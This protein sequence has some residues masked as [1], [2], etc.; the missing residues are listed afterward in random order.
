MWQPDII[1]ADA[2]QQNPKLEKTLQA[3]NG[4][5][6][7]DIKDIDEIFNKQFLDQINH[8]TADQILKSIPN[9]LKSDPEVQNVIRVFQ[10]RLNV[11]GNNQFNYQEATLAPISPELD[12]WNNI[13]NLSSYKKDIKKIKKTISQYL[14][15]IQWSTNLANLKNNLEMINKILNSDKAKL[16]DLRKIDQF[17]TNNGITD[18]NWDQTNIWPLLAW[19]TKFL[20]NI[21]QSMENH[22]NG[23]RVINTNRER[24]DR[25]NA[26]LQETLRE[27]ARC[28]INL[29]NKV[30]ND[31]WNLSEFSDK[32][33]KNITDYINESKYSSYNELRA[34]IF[35]VYYRMRQHK[36]LVDTNGKDANGNTIK[37]KDKENF[38]KIF[39]CIEDNYIKE[40]A[41]GAEQL[42]DYEL[43]LFFKNINKTNLQNLFTNSN[44][45]WNWENLEGDK[46]NNY[47][48]NN[49]CKWYHFTAEQ[50]KQRF[51]LI[52]KERVDHNINELK[53]FDKTSIF[54]QEELENFTIEETI[55]EE[56]GQQVT[57]KILKF[58]EI[59]LEPDGSNLVETL[60]LEDKARTQY[61]K[62]KWN[63]L[64]VNEEELINLIKSDEGKDIREE[65][66]KKILKAK[67][68]PA[69]TPTSNP[70]V[71]PDDLK[72]ILK[73]D[74]KT[75]L[76]DGLNRETI[77]KAFNEALTDENKNDNEKKIILSL[78]R[79]WLTNDRKD[80]PNN[81]SY[82][83]I[84]EL[85]EK[86]GCQP[87]DWKFGNGTFKAFLWKF[88]LNVQ[89]SPNPTKRAPEKKVENKGELSAGIKNF[90]DTQKVMYCHTA[91]RTVREEYWL[92]EEWD[93]YKSPNFNW[94]FYIQNNEL[95]YIPDMG[96]KAQNTLDNT[97]LIKKTTDWKNRFCENTY[98]KESKNFSEYLENA[99]NEAVWESITGSYNNNP[100]YIKFKN[101]N[102]YVALNNEISQYYTDCIISTSTIR[103][104][105]ISTKWKKRN[106]NRN[107]IRERLKDDLFL[108]NKRN[109]IQSYVKEAKVVNWIF[110]VNIKNKLPYSIK[111]TSTDTFNLTHE[112]ER[113]IQFNNNYK[114]LGWD[115]NQMDRYVQYLNRNIKYN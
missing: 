64:F 17:L 102:Y 46:Y 35:L 110:S 90:M 5:L 32:D 59:V 104:G 58:G 83:K 52:N 51:N 30:P 91:F 66:Y 93:I 2:E 81:D 72:E 111:L 60:W 85:Q 45:T 84:H 56:N 20:N 44:P 39:N 1:R 114:P 105:R 103:D 62:G 74:I 54:S 101:G 28:F 11:S 14:T 22:Q 98:P 95:F 48:T 27:R 86:L 4:I 43:D 107:D 94:Y 25:A 33:I 63:T 13:I 88:W 8:E 76:F 55:V 42:Q 3:I 82:K 23:N 115:S 41:P 69:N 87:I 70:E 57:K 67:D 100:P 106:A 50:F 18:L 24:I 15:Y 40:W 61:Q 71:T 9:D 75:T 79:Q 7:N 38:Y 108:I 34:Q 29:F 89:E 19:T 26:E 77:A 31:L 36:Q 12:D 99:I 97:P 47:I 80:D 96:N 109:E 113:P 92:P 49:L 78:T 73:S 53:G 10:T 16:K 37:S 65:R 21:K 112:K 68:K 6:E